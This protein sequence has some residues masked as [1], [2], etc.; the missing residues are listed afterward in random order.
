MSNQ[1][2]YKIGQEVEVH[3]PDGWL[4]GI[5]RGHAPAKQLSGELCYL[6]TGD[7]PSFITQVSERTMREVAA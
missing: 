1:R 5:V 4:R 6:V 2:N 7:K 3:L